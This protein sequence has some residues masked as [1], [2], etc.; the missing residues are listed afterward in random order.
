[1]FFG[2]FQHEQHDQGGH[3]TEHSV[4]TQSGVGSYLHECCSDATHSHMA[5]LGT[6]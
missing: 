6:A 2:G 1:M 4:V 3:A 5:W